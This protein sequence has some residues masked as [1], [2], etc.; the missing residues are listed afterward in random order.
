MPRSLVLLL[1]LVLALNYVDRSSLATPAP[2]IQKEFGL[3]SAELGYLLSAFFWGLHARAV[4]GR[5]AGAP[6]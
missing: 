3:T 2:V 5:M 6:L 1:S 4:A